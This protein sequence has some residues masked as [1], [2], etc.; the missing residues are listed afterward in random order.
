[1]G[2]TTSAIWHAS[3][4]ILSMDR[5]TPVIAKLISS[6]IVYTRFSLSYFEY[7]L[8]NRNRETP[9]NITKKL[10]YFMAPLNII[11]V[12]I[13]ICNFVSKFCN[14]MHYDRD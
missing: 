6:L 7:S 5:A 10:V 9:E 12:L 2:L 13:T 11:S 4:D 1:M 14:S 3:G 8:A